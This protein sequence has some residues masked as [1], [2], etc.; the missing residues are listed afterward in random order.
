M[1]F[2]TLVGCVSTGELKEK[3]ADL[4]KQNIYLQEQIG[5]QSTRELEEKIADLQK[6]NIYLQEQ[7]RLQSTDEQQIKAVIENSD[8]INIKILDDLQNEK[9][10][11]ASMNVPLQANITRLES[12]K[13]SL[14]SMNAALQANITRLESEKASLQKNATDEIRKLNSQIIVLEHQLEEFKRIE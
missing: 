1:S 9:A 12:E 14:A 13:A 11:L 7:I 4:Q 2:A 10:S 3:I 8:R 6:Q 5:L